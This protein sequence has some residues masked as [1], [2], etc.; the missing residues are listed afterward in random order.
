MTV[1][2]EKN[3][4][5]EKLDSRCGEIFKDQE[6]IRV[7]PDESERLIIRLVSGSVDHVS[8]FRGFNFTIRS[9]STS[10]GVKAWLIIIYIILTILIVLI[11][12]IGGFVVIKKHS[13]RA[14]HSRR[15]ESRWQG[16]R[17]SI[18]QSLHLQRTEDLG[19]QI[20]NN[21]E[22]GVENLNNDVLHDNIYS[23]ERMLGVPQ[24]S[25]PLRCGRSL[26]RTP[27]QEYLVMNSVQENIEEKT[28]KM[29]INNNND[30]A[31]A[32]YKIYE[33]LDS[34][35]ETPNP[36]V[37]QR[38]SWTL[39]VPDNDG[40]PTPVYLSM[41][42]QSNNVGDDERAEQRRD[43]LT[44]LVSITDTAKKIIRKM[45]L[46]VDNTQELINEDDSNESSDDDSVFC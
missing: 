19:Q 23:D 15:G 8:Q 43:P 27:D 42:D 36:S 5:R 44:S 30:G 26:P 13:P 41:P 25:V 29:T 28:E 33:S 18:G 12:M 21:N 35:L 37:P 1:E 20:N 17:P 9:V 14:R 32:I 2:V 3:G 38:P 31:V 46:Q 7:L 11:F 34:V 22:S 16:S 40:D 39:Q 10:V 45:S 4:R 6:I 24:Y